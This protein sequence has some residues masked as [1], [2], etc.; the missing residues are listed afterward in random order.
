MNCYSRLIVKHMMPIERV[1][2]EEANSIKH[3]NLITIYEAGTG[4]IGGAFQQS[5]SL[6]RFI[7][8]ES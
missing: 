4:H 8:A 6:P 2:R 5:T 1:L 3:R 7:L